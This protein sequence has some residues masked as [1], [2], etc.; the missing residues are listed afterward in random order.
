M[1]NG[2]NHLLDD[3]KKRGRPKGS[4]IVVATILA[5]LSADE[6]KK[7]EFLMKKWG[8]KTRSRTILKCLEKAFA[9]ENI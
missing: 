9:Q 5:N 6:L 7:I 3:E 1:E 4:K 2:Q 8:L